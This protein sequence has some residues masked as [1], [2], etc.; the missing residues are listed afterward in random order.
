MR[1][2]IFAATNPANAGAV[3]IYSDE[4]AKA[5]PQEGKND[6]NRVPDVTAT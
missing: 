1:S 5:G 6:R 4:S 2:S 3:T